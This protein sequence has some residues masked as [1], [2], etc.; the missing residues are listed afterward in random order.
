MAGSPDPS[1]PH[2]GRVLSV[3]GPEAI[4]GVSA[5]VILLFAA[6]VLLRPLGGGPPGSVPTST[7]GPSTSPVDRTPAPPPPSATRA[8]WA[9]SAATLI[10]V[11]QRL[12]DQRDE[13]AARLDPP[14]A[15]ADGI[16]QGLRAVNGQLLFALDVIGGLERQGVDPDLAE[17][18][19]ATHQAALDDSLNG[20][21]ASLSNVDSYLRTGQAVVD[22]LAAL[23]SL[24]AELAAA[25]GLPPPAG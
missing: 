20:L 12:R 11:D 14:P 24:M 19:R 15:R 25:S 3:L 5:V 4:G 2:L 23:E 10:D 18:L 13:L 9:S 21:D 1:Q 22:D 8:P 16:A 7:M 6:I 17:R